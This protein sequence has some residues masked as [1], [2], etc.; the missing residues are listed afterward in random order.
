MCER[1]F[2]GGESDQRSPVRSLVHN[3]KPFFA[4][5]DRELRNS[6]NEFCVA[7]FES[8][9][10]IQYGEIKVDVAKREPGVLQ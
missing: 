9:F 6:T 10:H 7:E 8:Y 2:L 3:K 5:R 1:G 4:T